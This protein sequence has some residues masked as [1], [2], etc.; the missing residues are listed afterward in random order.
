MRRGTAKEREFDRWKEEW[1]KIEA[2]IQKHRS[3]QQTQPPPKVISGQ[4]ALLLILKEKLATDPLPSNLSLMS[5]AKFQAR[6]GV[7]STPG[8]S[9]TL[10]HTLF[11]FFINLYVFLE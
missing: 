6:Q 1:P 5:L 11:H 3:T 8:F 10:V 4:Q 2:H 9:E 7:V